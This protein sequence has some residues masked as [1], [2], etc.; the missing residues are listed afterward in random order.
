MKGLRLKWC[1]GSF[2]CFSLVFLL[3][4]P[5][6]ALA[7][8]LDLGSAS[9]SPGSD[10]TIPITLD[11]GGATPNISATSN[12][13]GFNTDV[14]E[15]PR[16][17]IGPAGTATSK[18]VVSSTPSLGVFRVG[19]FGLNQN[20]IQNGIVANI[21][22]GIKAGASS[23]ETSLGNT[24]SASDPDGNPVEVSGSAGT[25]TVCT[26]PSI[27]AQPQSQTIPSGQTATL[28][29]TATGT[30]PLSYQWYWGSSGDI[31]NPVSGATS[32]SY[33]TPALTQTTSYWV[34]IWNAFGSVNSN[35]A[36]ISMRGIGTAT[37]NLPDYYTP[38][39]AS[40][41]SITVTPSETT[42]SYVVED[43]PPSG[44]T[45]SS[46]NENGQWDSVNKKVKWGSFFDHNP[47]T[48]TYQVTPPG[49]E[50]G[51]KTFSGTASFDGSNVS[52]GGDQT[53]G[54]M[55]VSYAINPNASYSYIHG[56]NQIT[57][58]QGNLNDGYF[59]LSLEDFDFQFYGISVTNIRIST[60][61]YITFGTNGTAFSNDLIPN[62]NLPNAIIAPFWDDLNLTGLGGEAGVWS[63]ISGTAPNRQLVVEWYQVPSF[64]YGTEMYSFEVIL[65]ESTDRIKF[66]YLD[67]DSGTSHDLGASATVGIENFD[68]T[69]GVQ[70]S[71]NGSEPLSNGLAIEF[72]PSNDVFS[73]VPYGYWAEGYITAIYNV[74]ITTGCAQDDPNTPENERRY[75]PEDYVTRSQMAAFIIRAKEGE[76]AQDYCG[77]GSPFSDVDANHWACKYIKRLY[78]L[79]ITT[80]CAQNPLRYCPDTL[81][82][83]DQMATFIVRAKEGE[84]SATYCSTGSPFSDVDANNWACKY[85][86]RLYELGITTGCAQNPL[87]YCP[88]DIVTRA[89]MAAFLARAFLGMQ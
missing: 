82:S 63:G 38:S 6:I 30:A 79:G 31:S 19:V 87:R 84:P 21:T 1:L 17:E 28:S 52:I 51:S 29:V 83:R 88:N 18:Q 11:Y 60:N 67:V 55:L 9:G 34:R 85:I 73:D 48:L 35:T 22:F 8:R 23:G 43:I 47:R 7:A 20:I 62:V 10:V 71:F 39:I 76:P 72:I 40:T 27:T 77:S 66:Q 12:D 57:S 75:C 89:Q 70:Y 56:N 33:T 44:W 5:G 69:E 26:A 74:G 14:L 80:G 4:M 64:E 50:T 25:I 24:P 37:R 65:Y 32:S 13:I 46:I 3:M 86:K 54:N 61:G 49:S 42:N 36:T 59:D 53:I 78:E 81:V 41:V 58:W 2:I 45:V 16:A 68:G 15:N